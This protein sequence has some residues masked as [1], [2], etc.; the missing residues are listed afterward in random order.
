MQT[1]RLK[2]LAVPS[3]QRSPL[4]PGV[5][6]IAETIPGFDSAAFNYLTAPTGTPAPVIARLNREV[7]GLLADPGFRK[8][9]G[10]LG[11]EPIGGT[12]EETGAFIAAERARW[13]EVILAANIRAE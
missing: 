7:N 10:E 2:A 6:T 11:L 5:P 8:R 12:P 9:L 3:P 1:G 4:A 13:R